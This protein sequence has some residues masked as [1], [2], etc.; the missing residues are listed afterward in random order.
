MFTNV[1]RSSPMSGNILEQITTLTITQAYKANLEAWRA[2]KLLD[3]LP[4][5]T[6]LKKCSRMFANS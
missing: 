3:K 2:L 1:W 5:L 6:G 4:R